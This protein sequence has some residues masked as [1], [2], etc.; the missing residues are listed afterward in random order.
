M[1]NPRRSIE[2]NTRVAEASVQ[3]RRDGTEP[4]IVVLRSFPLSMRTWDEVIL[5]VRD[6]FTCCRPDLIGLGQSHRA[7]GAD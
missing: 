3:W 7:A 5:R 6:R 1:V 4:P 2:A